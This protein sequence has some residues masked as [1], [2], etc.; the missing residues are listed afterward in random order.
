MPMMF[1]STNTTGD[2]L[3]TSICVTHIKSVLILAILNE[4]ELKIFYLPTT[5]PSGTG[6]NQIC[7]AGIEKEMRVKKE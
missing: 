5:N 7:G 2:P 3:C 4:I 6:W 1:L